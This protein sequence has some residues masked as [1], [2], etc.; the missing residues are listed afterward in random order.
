[1]TETRS[2]TL[3][4][5]ATGRDGDEATESLFDAIERAL[6]FQNEKTSQIGESV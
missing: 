1:M 4:K 3:A 6:D 2:Q 5:N